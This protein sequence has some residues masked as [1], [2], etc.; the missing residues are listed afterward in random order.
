M[1]LSF[2]G[3]A[4][5][6]VM[7]DGEPW[8]VAKDAADLL[9]YADT[10][11]AIKQHCR[12][13]AIHHPIVDS[14]GRTQNARIIAESDLLR[15]IIGSRLPAA[16]KFERWVFEDVCKVLDISNAPHAASRLDDEERMTIASNDGHSGQ[17][18]GAQSMT[19]INE[20][21]LYSLVLT[22]RKPEEKGVIG[23]PDSTG[24][25]QD[26]TVIT[27]AG[28]YRLVLRSDKPAADRFQSWVVKEV[29]PTIRKTGVGVSPP[30][31][32]RRLSLW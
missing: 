16:E 26:A 28:F 19:V 1:L 8:F 23:L 31:S 2:D 18:G 7:R 21:G 13:V 3:A 17:R 24:R 25:M 30:P 22:S 6:V 5:R 32:N 4:V 27:E 29:L 10:T 11:N 15:L 14:I 9:G 12:G 20:S